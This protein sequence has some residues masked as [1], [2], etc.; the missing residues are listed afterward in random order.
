MFYKPEF[1]AYLW[2]L[3]VTFMIVIPAVLVT[4]R[5]T[6]KAFKEAKTRTEENRTQG[7]EAYAKA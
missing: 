5:E 6:M 1:I 7:I 2:L 4:L 3:P